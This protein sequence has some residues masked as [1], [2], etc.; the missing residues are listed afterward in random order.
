MLTRRAPGLRTTPASA[1]ARL[2]TGLAI[3]TIQGYRYARVASLGRLGTASI[4]VVN[5]VSRR[6]RRL[7][8]GC[9][10]TEL[11]ARCGPA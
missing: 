3:L 7:H 6:V 1:E 2:G 10:F 8:G 4:L 5:L 9:S 11:Y